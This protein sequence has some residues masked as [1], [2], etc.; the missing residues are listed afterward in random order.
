MAKPKL[1]NEL[2]I[3]AIRPTPYCHRDYLKVLE[4][5]RI[6]YLYNDY[7]IDEKETISRKPSI[8]KQ[9][10]DDG[11]LKINISAIAGQNGSGK[12]TLIELLLMAINNISVNYEVNDDLKLVEGLG[13]ELYCQIGSYYKIRVIYNLVEVYRYNADNTIQDTPCEFNLGDLFY[14]IAINYSLYAYNSKELPEEQ[15]DWYHAM[16]HKNDSYQTPLVMNPQRIEGDIKVNLENNLARLRLMANILRDDRNS[17]FS[18]RRSTENL[19]AVKL[20]L[21]PNK[22]KS[23]NKR[24]DML[25]IILSES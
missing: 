19:V 3:I 2:K 7:T 17:R 18:F 11:K 22:T 8:P 25:P 10:F 15:P 16:F 1:I 5:D 23:Q 12:S 20:K 24:K 9:L 13:V 21:T 6:Y 4:P 14:T